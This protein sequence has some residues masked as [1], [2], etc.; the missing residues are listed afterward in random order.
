MFSVIFWN[1]LLFGSRYRVWRKGL[2]AADSH[3]QMK[4]WNVSL[5]CSTY[6]SDA[7]SHTTMKREQKTVNKTHSFQWDFHTWS[8]LWNRKIKAQSFICIYTMPP[9]VIL[10]NLAESKDHP[11]LSKNHC[12]LTYSHQNILQLLKTSKNNIQ[13]G[14]IHHPHF[15]HVVCYS[16]C[17]NVL[18]NV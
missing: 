2:W 18:V 10:I 16:A 8:F 1:I 5:D 17:M 7:K 11:I 14:F 4:P 3:Q 12:L 6:F 15:P 9:S 13:P